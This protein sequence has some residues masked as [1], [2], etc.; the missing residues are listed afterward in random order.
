MASVTA[1]GAGTRGN[2]TVT[3]YTTRLK[4]TAT[5]VIGW[6]ACFM[7]KGPIRAQVRK[8]TFGSA[9][10]ERVNNMGSGHALM[11][12][13]ASMSAIERTARSMATAR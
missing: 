11:L 9:N 1:Q 2:S 12:V 7:D 4:G 5:T 6:E 10:G 8:K 13:V 3:G